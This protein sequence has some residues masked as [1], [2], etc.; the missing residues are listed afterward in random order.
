MQLTTASEI[1]SF[2]K[3]LEDKAAKLYQELAARYPE[4]KEVFSSFAKENKKNETYSVIPVLV[5][6]ADMTKTIELS[7]TDTDGKQQRVYKAMAADGAHKGWVL[8]ASGP[9]FA[10]RIDLLIGLDPNVSTITGLYVLDQ[11]ETPGLGN[12]IADEPFRDQFAGKRADAD[13]PLIVVK[14]GPTTGNQILALTGGEKHLV[15]ERFHSFGIHTQ[16]L[17]DLEISNLTLFN[18]HHTEFHE[19]TALS[20]KSACRVLLRQ[21]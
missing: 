6:G 9:G 18:H 8:P 15:L 11:K 17:F 5:G 10:E 19:Q 4:A 13:Q 20:D 7:V 16:T 12:L 14:A 3:E 21:Y 2:A 1:I